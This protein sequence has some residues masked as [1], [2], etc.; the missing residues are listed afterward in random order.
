[1]LSRLFDEGLKRLEASPGYQAVADR[2]ERT[3]PFESAARGLA[4]STLSDEE[5]CARLR[6]WIGAPDD[7]VREAV[8]SSAHRRRSYAHDRAYRL[9]SAAA[10]NELVQPIDLA[11]VKLFRQEED[12]GRLP[13]DQAFDFLAEREPKLAQLRAEA[14]SQTTT[15]S[16]DPRHKA[17]HDSKRQLI[18][19]CRE[20]QRRADE[21]GTLLTRAIALEYL[22]VVASVGPPR[23][24]AESYFDHLADTDL[25]ER[26]PSASNS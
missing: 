10:S 17:D 12:V 5:A 26:P 25:G 2:V 13:L 9:L 20:H 22:R 3:E 4:Y 14:Q 6:E 21:L 8:E 15:R 16:P 23:D 11:S 18:Q 7:V 1:L 19:I 24:L